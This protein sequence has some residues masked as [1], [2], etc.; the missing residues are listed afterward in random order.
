MTLLVAGEG[1]SFIQTPDLAYL[2]VRRGDATVVLEAAPS[3]G[4]QDEDGR[5]LPMTQGE[6][7]TVPA[8]WSIRFRARRR[9]GALL[10]LE[11]PAGMTAPAA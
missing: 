10:V 6:M 1:W 11:H 4:Y 5:G 2:Q 3:D 8:G 9:N 7:V